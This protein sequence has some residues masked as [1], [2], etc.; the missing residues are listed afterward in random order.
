MEERW[1]QRE[2]LRY[3]GHRGQEIPENLD[4]LIRSCEAE[5]EQAAAPRA[6]WREYPLQIRDQ[7][8]DLGCFRTESRNLERNLR[9]C[10]RV[11][12]FGAT[13]GSGVDRLLE[14][15]KRL[16][17]SRALVLQAAS[18]AML[19]AF[20]D[21]ENEKIRQQ[22]LEA[23]WYLRPRFSPGYG[24]FALECQVFLVAALELPKRIGVTLTDSLVMAPSKSVTAVVGV[25]RLPRDC[26]VQGCEACGQ[27][28]CLYR[29]KTAAQGDT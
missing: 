26:T 27:T 6:L 4:A 13:L 20:C 18:A 8:L 17:M 9:D 29:R 1:N 5:L 7:V 22:Y 15:Y 14:R 2:I 28:D 16:Q 19:E 23:G 12:L 24:D 21:R 11:L 3:L 10:E 25:S